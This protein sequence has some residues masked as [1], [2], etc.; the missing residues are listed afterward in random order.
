MIQRAYKTELDPNNVQRTSLFQHAGAARRAYNWGL[1]RKIEAHKAGEKSP[2]AISLHRELNALKKVPKDDGGMP[3]MYE[4]SKCAPQEALRN[5]DKAFDGFFRRCKTKAKRKG[6]PRFKSRRKGIG[7]FTLTGAIHV[8][9]THVQLPRLGHLRLKEHGYVPIG[10]KI[11][12]ATVSERAGRWFV[13]LALEEENERT[14]GT[15]IL[16]VDVGIKSLAVLSDGTVFENPRALKAATQRLRRLQKGVS[17]KR[18][19]SR[20]RRK[21]KH[22]LARQ[23]YRVSCVRRDATH[24]ATTAIAKRCA[25]VGIESLNVSGMMKNHCLA[26]ALSDAG[27][28]EFLR[29]LKYKVAW[30]GGEVVEADRWFPSSK[31]CSVCGE[32]RHN[33]TLRDRVFHCVSCGH[34]QDRDENAA[35]NLRNM[36]VSSAV[37]ACGEESSGLVHLDPVKLSSVKQEPN[38]SQGLSLIGLV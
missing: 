26:G 12:R 32:V 33:L 28:S 3:W 8:S 10:A 27:M 29:C 23:H 6:F 36:A 2:S 30:H 34:I 9:E 22:R 19:G 7:S 37:S 15:E 4:V 11:T 14:V 38:A 13:S 5:L 31:M 35:C 16:G 18:K 25:V 1:G 24:K 20:N 17:R 21:A